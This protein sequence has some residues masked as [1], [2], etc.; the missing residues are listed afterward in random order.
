MSYDIRICVKAEGCDKYPAIAE[1]ELSSPTYNLG[2]MFRKCMCWDYSQGN[3]YK[4]DFVIEK[5][6]HGIK[7]LKDNRNK[8]IKYNPKNGWGNIDGAIDV[9]ESL[10]T[11]IY[12]QAE[13][14]PIDCLYMCW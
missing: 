9:L 12:E 3:Y 8:Y 7:E 10:R 14:I 13:D 2:T 5:V 4:C 6:E 11:C 1:P